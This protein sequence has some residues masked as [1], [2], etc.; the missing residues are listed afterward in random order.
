MRLES[1]GLFCQTSVFQQL[2]SGPFVQPNLKGGT[3]LLGLAA[4]SEG[5]TS[6]SLGLGPSSHRLIG[7]GEV[8]VALQGVGV[9]AAQ[10]GFA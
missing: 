10:L 5:A 1:N 4:A 6:Q 7:P 8:D 2:F 3:F 9:V